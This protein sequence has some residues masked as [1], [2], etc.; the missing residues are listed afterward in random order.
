M[1]YT[2]RK[3]N[4]LARVLLSSI[5]SMCIC[6]LSFV[7][8][9]WAWFVDSETVSVNSIQAG[10]ENENKLTVLVTELPEE[11]AVGFAFPEELQISE[12]DGEYFFA[13]LANRSYAV[14]AT[15]DEALYEGGLLVNVGE[16]V[17]YRPFDGNLSYYFQLS[18]DKDCEVKISLADSEPE[19][20]WNLFNEEITNI[21]TTVA[22][23]ICSCT[24]TCT[25]EELNAECAL[26]S[27]DWLN[28]QFKDEQV[29]VD[30]C[31]C[32]DEKC[33]EDR[34]NLLCE[35]CMNDMSECLAELEEPGEEIELPELEDETE[36]DDKA[37]SETEETSPPESDDEIIDDEIA[38]DEVIEDSDDEAEDDESTEAS[39]ENSGEASDSEEIISSDEE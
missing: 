32:A 4:N 3:K 15:P 17:Y 9:T 34:I 35:V 38:D 36:S 37:E 21:E 27:V 22:P 29:K 13:V 28:C 10:W 19:G 24:T 12:N 31:I 2:Y 33:A 1:N 7:G 16:A 18:L 6:T 30:S 39:E 20:D 26:C 23:L 11:E 8:S 14:E 5:L 25:E